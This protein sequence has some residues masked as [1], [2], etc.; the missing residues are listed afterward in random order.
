MEIIKQIKAAETQ[1]KEIIEKAKAESVQIS[2][3]FSK[4][5]QK[6]G[7]LPHFPDYC[8]FTAARSF[9]RSWSTGGICRIYRQGEVS[10]RTGNNYSSR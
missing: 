2:E 7:N 9:I 8:S 10:C 6:Q 5:S 4:K 3:D 1:A